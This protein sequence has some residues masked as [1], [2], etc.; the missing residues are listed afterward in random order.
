MCRYTVRQSRIYS[1]ANE[2]RSI[3]AF[4]DITV[5]QLDQQGGRHVFLLVAL[6][7]ISP[8]KPSGCKLHCFRDGKG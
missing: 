5:L 7:F 6:R 4:Y 3:I 1:N 8:G 2:R